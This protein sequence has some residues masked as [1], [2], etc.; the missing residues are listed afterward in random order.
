[1]KKCLVVTG[2]SIDISFVKDFLQNRNYDWVIAVDAG[3]EI[4][5]SLHIVPD[6]VVGDLDTVEQ[7][8]LKEYR[9]NPSVTFEIHKP[10]KDETDTELA[11]LTAA[12]CGCDRVDLLGALGGRMDHEISNIQ[13]IYQFFKQGMEVC[14]YDAQNKLYLLDGGKVF[15][16]S[17]LYGKYISFMPLT[18]VVSGLTL[19]GFKYPLNRRRIELGSC[20][21]ISNE[22]NGEE[23]IMEV[24]SGVLI[25]V[26]AHD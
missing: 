2:G 7:S 19:K 8:V 4:L 10:E 20:L 22:L 1:M 18:E 6:E 26:E 14:I 9:D 12:R 15:R 11:L 24:E 25:C 23:G 3:L 16:R 21:C 5:N 17:E 13:L